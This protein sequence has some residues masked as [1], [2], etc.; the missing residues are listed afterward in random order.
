MKEYD[1]SCERWREYSFGE[2]EDTLRVVTIMTPQKLFISASGST[3]RV[4]NS[5]GVITCVPAPGRNLCVL[6][7]LAKD[8]DKPVAF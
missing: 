2:D 7:W 5:D 8:S 6:S 3:H 4:L 1:I